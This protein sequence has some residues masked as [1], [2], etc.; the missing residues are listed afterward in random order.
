MLLNGSLAHW[1]GQTPLEAA[2]K[3]AY[4]TGWSPLVDLN[5]GTPLLLPTSTRVHITAHATHRYSFQN[6][7]RFDESLSLIDIWGRITARGAVPADISA[8]SSVQQTYKRSPLQQEGTAT[9]SDGALSSGEET[10][11][12]SKTSDAAYREAL[13]CRAGRRAAWHRCAPCTD[14]T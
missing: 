9:S 12:A 4:K 6:P 13:N 7:A 1:Q 5:F 11:K 8:R 14:Y 10:A 3:N 2:D